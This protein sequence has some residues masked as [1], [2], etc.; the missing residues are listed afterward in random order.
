[1]LEQLLKERKEMINKIYMC[2]NAWQRADLLSSV[3]SFD[4]EILWKY[5]DSKEVNSKLLE[6]L[7]FYENNN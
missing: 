3:R 2:A 7:K 4:R 5:M 6:E 1:M